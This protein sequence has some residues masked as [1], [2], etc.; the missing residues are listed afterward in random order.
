MKVLYEYFWN[1]NDLKVGRLCGAGATLRVL[2]ILH[3]KQY[4]K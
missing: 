4:Y 2:K 3:H 1:Y